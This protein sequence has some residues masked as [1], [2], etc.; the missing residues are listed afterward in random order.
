MLRSNAST[1]YSALIQ[2]GDANEDVYQRFIYI[3]DF[4][5]FHL[6]LFSHM[7]PTG[8]ETESIF[9]CLICQAARNFKKGIHIA[10]EFNMQLL[11]G[12]FM[13][14]LCPS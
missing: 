11:S 2:F 3:S 4:M 1:V 10:Y 5:S 8:I 9:K 12:L 13:L 7:H 6:Q 14:C